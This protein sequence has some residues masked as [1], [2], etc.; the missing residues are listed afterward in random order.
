MRL[1][2]LLICSVYQLS[3]FAQLHIVAAENFYGDVA[4][5]LG[6]NQVQ[7]IS[8]LQNP[9]QDPHLFTASPSI[10]K[11]IAGADIVVYNG[12]DYDGW[13][14]KLLSAVS[15]K[16]HIVIVVADL[17]GIKAGENPHIWYMPTTM[18]RYAEALSKQLVRLDPAH[19]NDYTKRLTQ[20]QLKQ[21]ALQDKIK[22]L[23]Q[24]TDGLAVTAT[25]PVFNWMAA[26]LGFQIRHLDFQQSVE[27]ESSPS[28]AAMK[29]MLDDLNHHKIRILFYNMQ[30]TSPLVNQV[31]EVAK[32]NQVPVVGVTE[33]QPT[34]MDY[35][36]W[37]NKELADV[38]RVFNP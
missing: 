31:V 30:V 24:K 10:A 17:M 22:Q 21:T 12:A 38:A 29:K 13:M 27:N 14:A 25:E 3:A 4:K 28:P 36:H 8:I 26:A 34:E 9:E 35:H 1:L 33:T 15:A 19:T 20:F 2:I 11:A 23:K 6:G 18:S 16:Q 5:E 7:V 32:K 37:M